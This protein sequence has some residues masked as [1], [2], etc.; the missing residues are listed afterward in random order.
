MKRRLVYNIILAL[1]VTSCTAQKDSMFS[2]KT[3]DSIIKDE[4]VKFDFAKNVFRPVLRDIEDNDLISINIDSMF[5]E[6]NKK[7]KIFGNL[8]FIDSKELKELEIY[9]AYNFENTSYKQ[10]QKLQYRIDKKQI[11]IF[12]ALYNPDKISVLLI[13]NVFS[14]SC[15]TIYMNHQ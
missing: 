12:D 5:I 2:I 15:I 11:I 9:Q 4:K 3:Q 10:G 8:N 1:T 14:P 7:I 13:S 6:K